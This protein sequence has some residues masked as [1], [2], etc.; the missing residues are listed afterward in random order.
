MKSKTEVQI[1]YPEEQNGVPGIG[2]AFHHGRF[3]MS[4]RK[5]AQAEPK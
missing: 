4:L 2:K 3:V 5:A 1:P